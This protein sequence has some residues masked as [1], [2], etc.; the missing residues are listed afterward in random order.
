MEAAS[1]H[2]QFS[3]SPTLTVWKTITMRI[4]TLASGLSLLVASTSGQMQ[5]SN[6]PPL[7]SE[8]NPYT[9]DR[10][11]DYSMTNPLRK[12]GSDFPCKGYHLELSTPLGEPVVKMQGGKSYRM[13]FTGGT[14]HE[15]GSCQVSLS[16]D[17]GST[18]YV[19]HSYIGNCPATSGNNTLPFRVPSDVPL[20]QRALFAW[21]W[22]NKLGSRE[23][24]MNCASVTTLHEG[25]DKIDFFD[26]PRMFV[27]NIGNGCTTEESEDV[28]F[29]DPGPELTIKN[30]AAAPPIG[31][32]DPSK[33]RAPARKE[34]EEGKD[35]KKEENKEENKEEGC[36]GPA[37]RT[38]EKTGE[39]SV[40]LIPGSFV[41]G[42]AD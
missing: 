27:A 16:V 42:E 7:R 19:L 15:G 28:G 23:M 36:S 22:F 38:R 8:F 21:T 11:I 29:P 17:G 34:K 26:R 3:T 40:T 4:T 14:S 35:E 25:P 30:L 5:M 33:I 24:Y 39:H 12:D 13:T 6:P 18:F 2:A 41:I 10:N 9:T 37:D 1:N 31:L 20:V 32:C